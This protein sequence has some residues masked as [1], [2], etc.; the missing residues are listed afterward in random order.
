M[1]CKTLLSRIFL[2]PLFRSKEEVREEVARFDDLRIVYFSIVQS[3]RFR[4]I[5]DKPSLFFHWKVYI[6]RETRKLARLVREKDLETTRHDAVPMGKFRLPARSTPCVLYIY[7]RISIILESF[8]C[9]VSVIRPQG[10]YIT[11][12]FDTF[13]FRVYAHLFT[14]KVF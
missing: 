9:Y 14:S 2:H 5:P 6:L 10:Y 1:L 3:F 8:F 12:N 13:F 11:L 4:A 7:I